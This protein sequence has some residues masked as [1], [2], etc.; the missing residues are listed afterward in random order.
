MIHCGEAPTTTTPRPGAVR[1]VSLSPAISSTLRDLG[2]D[3][4]VVGRTPWCDALDP[5]VPV[6]GTLL[7]VDAERLARLRP[8]HILVQ[9]PA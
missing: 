1:V 5:D 4:L 6:V 8:T 3:P 2:L 7:D 9:P